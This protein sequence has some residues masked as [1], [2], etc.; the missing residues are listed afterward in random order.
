MAATHPSWLPG[1]VVPT[2]AHVPMYIAPDY[3]SAHKH[4]LR[5]AVLTMRIFNNSNGELPVIHT[6]WI[7]KNVNKYV[8]TL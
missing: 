4:V 3:L 7:C 8:F 5:S 6:P 2:E 1:F